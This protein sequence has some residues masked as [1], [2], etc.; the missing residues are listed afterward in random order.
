[1][2]AGEDVRAERSGTDVDHE[3]CTAEDYA[4]DNL[5]IL[6]EEVAESVDLSREI[7]RLDSLNSYT[8]VSCLTATA[9]FSTIESLSLS[10]PALDVKILHSATIMVSSL[11]AFSGIY[12]TV[13]FSL[14]S[15]VSLQDRRM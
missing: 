4:T 7:T 12:S 14:C 10:D 15:A 6:V 13:V 1:M 5:N 2:A 8:I 3:E 9:S 11:A